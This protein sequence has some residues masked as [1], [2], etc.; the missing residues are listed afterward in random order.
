MY[1]FERSFLNGLYERYHEGDPMIKEVIATQFKDWFKYRIVLFKCRWVDPMRGMK[2]HP[3]YHLVD[4]N[5]K[6]VY[7]KNEPFILAQQ[8]V[9]VFYME[10]R[11]MKRNKVDWQAL[12]KIKVRRVIDESRW[13]E[14]AFQEDETV[15]TPQVLTDEQDYELHDP[16]GIKLV[17]DLN[18]EGVG[19]SRTARTDSDNEPEEESFEE[20]DYETED[21]NNYD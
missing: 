2:M 21:D 20:G 18:Q 17:F 5:F 12:C 7:Q 19:T 15:P 1:P 9:Q 6:K 8:A 14:V 3:N 13:T 11:S 10:Y 16:T 4:V